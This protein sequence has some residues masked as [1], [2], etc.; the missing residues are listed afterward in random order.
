MRT[1]RLVAT[2]RR[3]YA[4]EAVLS[5]GGG[6]LDYRPRHRT[7]NLTPEVTRGQR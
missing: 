2:D 1:A 4:R 3:R 6:Q 7:P 5:L